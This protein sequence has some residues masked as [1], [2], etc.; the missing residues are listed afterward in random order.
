M[1]TDWYEDAKGRVIFDNSLDEDHDHDEGSRY[2][3]VHDRCKL[4]YSVK[5]LNNC[6]FKEEHRKGLVST[7]MSN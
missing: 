3:Y 1:S 2:G 7:T 6:L 4:K 5:N